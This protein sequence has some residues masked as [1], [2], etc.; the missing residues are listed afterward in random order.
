MSSKKISIPHIIVKKHK[1][2]SKE[3]KFWCSWH[4]HAM[5]PSLRHGEDGFDTLTRQIQSQVPTNY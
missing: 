3:D 4:T 1:K 2:L 5:P